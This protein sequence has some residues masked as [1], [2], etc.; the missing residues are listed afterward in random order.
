MRAEHSAQANSGFSELRCRTKQLG[1][2]IAIA[3]AIGVFIYSHLL[4]W[5]YTI[6]DAFITY[7]YSANLAAGLGPVFN[8]GQPVEGYTNPLWMLLL[9]LPAWLGL[10]LTSVSKLLAIACGIATATIIVYF[11]LKHKYAN[12]TIVLL[13]GG[14]TLAHPVLLISQ[15]EGL[16]TSLF[17]LLLML[18]AWLLFPPATT[19]KNRLGLA[20]ITLT[21]L[22]LTRPDGILA[23]ASVLVALRF[24]PLRATDW[25]R[26]IIVLPGLILC[27]HLLWRWQ[28]YGYLLPN[29]FYLKQGGDWISFSAG[30][31]EIGSFM[32][33]TAG[34]A[35]WVPL[36]CLFRRMRD[37]L[38]IFLCLFI[39]FRFLFVL[40]TGGEW[41][42]LHR[43]LAPSI[44][45]AL[46]LLGK[47]AFVSIQDSTRMKIFGHAVI[48][49]VLLSVT[50]FFGVQAIPKR[51]LDGERHQQSTVRVAQFL[52]Q[53][54]KPTDLIAVLDAGAIPY[55]SNL[56]TL[57]LL[58]L[59][60]A[61]LAHNATKSKNIHK[62]FRVTLE[63]ERDRDYVFEQQPKWIVLQTTAAEADAVLTDRRPTVRNLAHDRRFSSQYQHVRGFEYSPRYHYQLF[64]R[65]LLLE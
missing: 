20:G 17:T 32:L 40:Y 12:S 3:S 33:C 28:Y 42:G 35:L 5:Q 25:W 7:R 61:H 57:D 59:N 27:A 2:L 44:P 15:A 45:C 52:K 43:F 64:R 58:G 54:S 30:L 65:V 60:D 55:Y 36:L 34:I 56:P 53:N 49:A 21:L 46:L 41:M 10:P 37:P 29:T 38:T 23:Y 31:A 18:S 47:L 50:L 16:E 39:L 13:I 11:L 1:L 19:T 14:L 6:D 9:A 22:M 48:G 4:L 26:S 62:H 51:V 63:A 8:A 24:S